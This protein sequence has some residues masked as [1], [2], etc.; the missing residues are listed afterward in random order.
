[1]E[2][3]K[4]LKIAN[5]K[6]TGEKIEREIHEDLDFMQDFYQSGKTGNVCYKVGTS[7]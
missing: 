5:E 1:M 2:L 6:G 3:T 7:L 4:E